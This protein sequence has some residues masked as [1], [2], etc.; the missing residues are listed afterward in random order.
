MLTTFQASSFESTSV[1]K[2]L[3]INS[4]HIKCRQ[5][6]VEVNSGL[7]KCSERDL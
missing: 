1:V 5:L 7:I 3:S 6:P 4:C 2:G